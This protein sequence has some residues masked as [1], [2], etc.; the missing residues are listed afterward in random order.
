MKTKVLYFILAILI[1]FI[2]SCEDDSEN[3][4][5]NN[6]NTNGKVSIITEDIT[7]FT[8]WYSDTVYIIENYD[9]WVTNTLVI[10]A[11]TVVKFTNKGPGMYVD[12]DGVVVAEGTVDNPIVF[13]SYKDDTHGGDQNGDGSATSPA[14]GDWSKIEVVPNGSKFI[15]CEFYYGGSDSYLSTL[16]LYGARATVTNCKFVNNKGGKFGDFYYGVLSASDADDQ[17]VIKN[18]IFYNNILPLSIVTTQTLDNSNVFH[19]PENVNE[20]NSMNGIFVY[21]Y[22]DIEKATKW[23][24]DEVPFV[25]SSNQLRV[26][27]GIV[28]TLGSKVVLKFTNGAAMELNDASSSINQVGNNIFTSFKDDTWLGDTNA[29]GSASSPSDGDWIGIYNNNII[30]GGDYFNWSNIYYSQYP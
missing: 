11:G 30:S 5:G 25:I 3:N 21:D 15:Y 6:A 12:D 24:E 20:K 29:D 16:M 19:N 17:S 1:A 26:E 2:S 9:F 23:E 18:N 27:D 8:T 14:A 22:S 28:L 4:N 7:S 13:T 10:Q